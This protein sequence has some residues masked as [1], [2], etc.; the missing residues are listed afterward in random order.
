MKYAKSNFTVI[1]MGSWVVNCQSDLKSTTFTINSESMHEAPLSKVEFLSFFKLTSI[2]GIF[3]LFIKI[4][5]ISLFVRKISD[6]SNL[7]DNFPF[8]PI[9]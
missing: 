9:R 4:I 6:C 2:V 5:K 7:G 1:K 8:S 3:S